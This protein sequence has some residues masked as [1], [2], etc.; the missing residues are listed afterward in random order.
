VVGA[1]PEHYLQRRTEVGGHEVLHGIRFLGGDVRQPFVDLLG[2]AAPIDEAI[3]A[4]RR[5]W[6]RFAP[7]RVR[8]WAG[9]TPP[10]EGATVDQWLLAGRPRPDTA[11]A[12]HDAD[13][14]EAVDWAERQLVAWREQHPW[15]IGRVFA[16]DAEQA[17]ACADDH[18]LCW[19]M[20]GAQRVG[21]WGVRRGRLREWTGWE[22]VEQVI[23]PGHSGRGLAAAAQRA[24]ASRRPEEVVFGT[25]DGDNEASLRTAARAGRER[26]AAWWWC[27]TS[28]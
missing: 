16:L 15:M 10:V 18:G 25:I 8:V 13:P 17:R 27:G 23:A 21:L 9:S 20:D 7:E 11:V 3:A 12:L 2:T 6:P 14:A 28:G 22:V 5:A 4:V 1:D 19:V 24:W 26:V